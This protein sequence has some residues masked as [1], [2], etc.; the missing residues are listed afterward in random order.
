VQQVS[1]LFYF[2]SGARGI[3][4]QIYFVQNVLNKRNGE[5]WERDLMIK[6]QQLALKGSSEISDKV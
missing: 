1:V 3:F 2:C 4:T 5:G 6:R